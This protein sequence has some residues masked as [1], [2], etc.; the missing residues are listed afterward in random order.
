MFA[1][2]DKPFAKANIFA[3]NIETVK[4]RRF[5]KL[6]GGIPSR[7]FRLATAPDSA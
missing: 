1:K 5:G 2:P 7:R 4:M 6:G 3:A